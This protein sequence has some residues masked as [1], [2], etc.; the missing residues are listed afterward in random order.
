MAKVVG[1]ERFNLIMC[2]TISPPNESKWK[3][4]FVCYWEPAGVLASYDIINSATN[5]L[6][7]VKTS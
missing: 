7:Y 3:K 2:C 4:M 6:K 1:K 5:V